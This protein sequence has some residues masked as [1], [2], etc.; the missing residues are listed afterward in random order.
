[1]LGYI[2]HITN[3]VNGKKYIGKSTNLP[4]RIE[5]HL[6]DLTLG[7]HHSIKLQRAFDKYGS[8]NFVFSYQEVL[9]ENEEELSLLEM[10][11]ID[12][13]DSYKN[14]YNMTLGGEGHST[15]LDFET[16]VLVYNILKKYAGINRKLGRYYDCDPSV[17]ASLSENYF[18]DNVDY[19]LEKMNKLIEKIEISEENLKENYIPHNEQKLDKQSCLEIL[20]VITK[21]E[22]YDKTLCEIFGITSKLTYRL[23]KHEIYKDYIKIFEQLSEDEKEILRKETFKKYDLEHRRAARQRKGVK[24]PLTQDQ[25]NYILDN[26]DKKAKAAIARDLGISADR[27]SAVILGKSYKDLVANYYSSTN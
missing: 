7:K 13:Y 5:T 16:Q 4:H 3:Q 19:S 25:V 17:F 12:K 23:R 15:V 24:N 10:K 20:S 14:G 27:V 22:G 11:E 1:M 21:Q 26:K 9:A 2:Y 18:L 8:K 6:S